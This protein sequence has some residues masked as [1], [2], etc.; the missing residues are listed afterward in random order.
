MRNTPELLDAKYP[1]IEELRFFLRSCGQV[2]SVRAIVDLTS[3]SDLSPLL[4][5]VTGG[6]TPTIGQRLFCDKIMNTISS[7]HS[8]TE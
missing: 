7:I 6:H 5:P 4:A 1:G 8:D 3:S 2:P